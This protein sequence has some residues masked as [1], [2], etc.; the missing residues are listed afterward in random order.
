[1]IGNVF[2]QACGRNQR[3]ESIVPETA[4]HQ[5]QALFNTSILYSAL[6]SFHPHQVDKI[7]PQI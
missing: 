6:C 4:F 7:P 1:M 2:D 5:F 3:Q